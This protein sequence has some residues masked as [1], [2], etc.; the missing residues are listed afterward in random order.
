MKKLAVVII[1]VLMMMASVAMADNMKI[2]L[3]HA[4]SYSGVI[5]EMD[6]VRQHAIWEGGVAAKCRRVNDS[7]LYKIYGWCKEYL[8]THPD[9]APSDETLLNDIITEYYERCKTEIISVT[10]TILIDSDAKTGWL[11][12]E[13]I[14]KD[15]AIITFGK[16]KLKVY[17]CGRVDRLEWKTMIENPNNVLEI[18]TGTFLVPNDLIGGGLTE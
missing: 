11:T 2:Y 10:P 13:W 4:E 3:K 17:K 7:E 9:M 16:T 14:D 12:T 15:T 6:G 18:Q 5:V 1:M 8:A